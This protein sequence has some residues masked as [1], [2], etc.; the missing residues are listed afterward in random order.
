MTALF[1]VHSTIDSE[2]EEITHQLTSV[3]ES[4]LSRAIPLEF[5]EHISR[6]IIIPNPQE[7]ISQSIHLLE[8]E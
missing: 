1:D 5:V 7:T 6:F 4:P 2:M 3:Q 8:T